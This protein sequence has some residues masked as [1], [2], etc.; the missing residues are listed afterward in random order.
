MSVG[1]YILAVGGW[2]WMVVNTYWRVVSVHG[3]R[4]ICFRWQWVMVI[5]G[6]Y[7]LAGGGCGGYIWLVAGGGGDCLNLGLYLDLDL[8]GQVKLF[9]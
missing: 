5:G 2:R 3:L 7:I 1:E 6:G 8:N 4:W 9:K